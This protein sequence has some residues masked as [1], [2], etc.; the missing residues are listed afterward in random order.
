MTQRY[1]QRDSRGRFTGSG[2]PTP[3]NDGQGDTSAYDHVVTPAGDPV[4]EHVAPVGTVYPE[5]V[6]DPRFGAAQRRIPHRRARV[7][8]AQTGEELS[9]HIADVRAIQTRPGGRTTT[10]V[11]QVE[12]EEPFESEA[13][14]PD[15]MRGYRRIPGTG[16]RLPSKGQTD[17]PPAPTG[18]PELDDGRGIF[19][20]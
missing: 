4:G 7:I 17:D 1:S 2:A 9:R 14:P 13:L 10:H 19:R 5:P 8:N 3:G 6:H 11:V 12:G 20:Y 15:T 16:Y 18:Y